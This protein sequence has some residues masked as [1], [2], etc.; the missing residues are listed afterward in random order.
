MS[1]L[2]F[3]REGALA[4]LTTLVEAGYSTTLRVPVSH[5]QAYWNLSCSVRDS[6]DIRGFLD[7]IE[8]L[9]LEAHISSAV[10]GEFS[11]HPRNP[12]P[13]WAR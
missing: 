4:A 5:E 3:D 11:L 7:V 12:M 6:E 8:G 13:R 2:Q 1:L 9:D 10:G